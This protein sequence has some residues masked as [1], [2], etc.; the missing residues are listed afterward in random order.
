MAPSRLSRL[1]GP[2]SFR[3]SLADYL[4]QHFVRYLALA[5][6]SGNERLATF[7]AL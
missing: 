2:A 5:L 6:E 4:A 3:L 1:R 7:R